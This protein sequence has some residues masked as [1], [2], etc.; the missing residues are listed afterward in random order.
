MFKIIHD[1]PGK[2][3]IPQSGE[4]HRKCT[5]VYKGEG[6]RHKC[7]HPLLETARCHRKL[8]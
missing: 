7:M 1:N 6:I 3:D 5:K 2:E 8:R 4:Y